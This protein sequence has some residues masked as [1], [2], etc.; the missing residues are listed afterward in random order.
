MEQIKI[1]LSGSVQKGDSDRR[2]QS[3]YWSNEE[4]DRLCKLISNAMPELLNPNRVTID[5]SRSMERF[6]VDLDMLLDCDIVVV[7][8]RTKKGIGVG[9]EMMMASYEKIPVL[10]LC[11]EGSEYRRDGN[12]HAFVVGLCRGVFDSLEDLARE[13]ENLIDCEVLPRKRDAHRRSDV[14]V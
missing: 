9:A 11:P 1:F 8:A 5:R 7:D 12:T 3:N 13:I 10:A 14:D 2:S 6:K 4:E